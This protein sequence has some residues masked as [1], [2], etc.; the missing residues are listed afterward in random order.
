MKFDKEMLFAGTDKGVILVWKAKGPF[1]LVASLTGHTAIVVCLRI[2][3]SATKLYSGLVDH[4]IKNCT[5]KVWHITEAG[6][7]NLEVIYTH[8]VEHGIVALF[9]MYDAEVKPVLFC[10]STDN[11]IRLYDL[12]SFNKRAILF[13]KQ[14]V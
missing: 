1:E 13:G 4:T 8:D 7:F 9:V 12:P 14:E 10:S 2:G 11:S 3:S 5:I 6:K